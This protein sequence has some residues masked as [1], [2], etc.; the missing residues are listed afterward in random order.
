MTTTTSTTTS[1]APASAPAVGAKRDPIA[2]TLRS[3]L[4]I[5]LIALTVFFTVQNSLFLTAGNLKNIAL[6]GAVLLVV[7]V[8]QALLVIMGVV[9]LSVGSVIGLSGVVAGLLIVDHGMAWQVAALIGIALGAL[10]GF[11][12]GLL[13]SFTRLSPIIVTLGTLQLYRGV[14]QFLR[15]NPPAN[16]GKGMNLLGRGLYLGIPVPVWIAAV[17]F[18]I[19]AVV[20]YA[21]PYGR[22]V[23]AIGVNK[24]A[25]FLSGVATRA[26]PLVAYAAT[27]AAAG[28][29]G[30]LLSAQLDSAPPGTLG[31]G[32]EL[33]VLTA[34]LLGGIAFSGG[35]G[36]MFGVLLGV[37]FL[38]VLNNGMTLMN[39]PYYAQAMATGA[40]LIIGA[41]LDE[42]SQHSQLIRAI[43]RRR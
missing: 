39:V 11:G 4:L 19:G 3:A 15:S 29:G 20:L 10:A 33:N 8:P 37:A 40:A 6:S 9:D 13:V 7:A 17:V 43:G 42:L 21:T 32:F 30:V 34:V 23:Y 28:I 24:E 35:R 25:A 16:F 26:L 5:G 12:N 14:S 36:T 22:Y 38:G 2:V 1:A 41:G 31:V 27:G 18:V